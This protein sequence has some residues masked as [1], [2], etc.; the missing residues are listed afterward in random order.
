MLAKN[1]SANFRGSVQLPLPVVDLPV[2]VPA[3]EAEVTLWADFASADDRGVPLYLVNQTNDPQSFGCQD[4]DVYV[5]LEYRDATGTWKRAQALLSSWCGNS[6][7]SVTLPPRQF[8]AF[9]GYR[10]AAGKKHPVRYAMHGSALAS[11]EAEGFITDDDL[12][13]VAVDGMTA[14]ELPREFQGALARLPSQPLEGKTLKNLT[15]AVRSL[16][17]YTRHE[18]AITRAKDLRAKVLALPSEPDRDDLLKAMDEFLAKSDEPKPTPEQLAELCIARLAGAA[19]ADPLMTEAMAWKLLTGPSVYGP[20]LSEAAKALPPGRWRGVIGPAAAQLMRDQQVLA[21]GGAD[22]VL[23]TGW[24]VDCLVKDD[25][26]RA[27]LSQS[28]SERLQ[29]LGAK[30]LTR[31][32]RFSDLV[33]F[34]W[35]QPGATQIKILKVLV[36]GEP[37]AGS[38]RVVFRQPSFKDDEHVFWEHCA[39]TMPIETANALWR[40]EFTTQG[41]PFNRLIHDPLRDHFKGEAAHATVETEIDQEDVYPLRVALRMLASWRMKED[42]RVMTALLQHG[43]YAIEESLT[44]PNLNK[45]VITK[46]FIVREMAREALMARGQPLPPD[47]VVESVISETEVKKTPTPEPDAAKDFSPDPFGPIPQ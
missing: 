5:K 14:S 11:N 45:R 10:P 18:L 34:A 33:A 38:E 47:L 26:L 3:P 31:R 9:R 30:A 13:A 29:Y 8:F 22:A 44:G 27:W 20:E 6:Y 15:E 24:I 7:Y 41:N 25:G 46:R 39:R 4:N 17:W 1:P 12:A 2:H 43:A 16:R 35:K 19:G 37:I 36:G 28:D 23:S 42:D 21:G 32:H 40:W